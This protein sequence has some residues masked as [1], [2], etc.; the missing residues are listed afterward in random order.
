VRLRNKQRDSTEHLCMISIQKLSV[1]CLYSMR[2]SLVTGVPAKA[3]SEIADFTNRSLIVPAI[4]STMTPPQDTRRTL[5][6][7]PPQ[8][9]AIWG[10]DLGLRFGPARLPCGFD[11]N[12]TFR[13]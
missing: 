5:R 9:A 10:C 13:S 6:H 7:D 12:R 2:T 3:V 11:S 4:D 1:H 8:W